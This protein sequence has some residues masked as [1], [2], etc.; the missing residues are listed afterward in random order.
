MKKFLSFLMVLLTS[1]MVCKADYNFDD[2]V[3]PIGSRSY[4]SKAL[5]GE[6]I[7]RMQF[8]IKSQYGGSRYLVEGS[9]ING[10]NSSAFYR[11]KIKDNAVV[12]DFQIYQNALIGSAEYR[13]NIT[14]FAFPI[15]EKPYNWTEI[16]KGDKYQCTSEYVHI[17]ASEKYF[18]AIKI[19]KDN[20][21]TVG[22]EKH[23]EIEKSYWIKGY[24][25]I[26]TLRDLDGV[27]II[28]SQL[29]T[30]GT[31]IFAN[32]LEVPEEEYNAYLKK[33]KEMEIF[34]EAIKP[35]SFQQKYPIYYK[36]VLDII[37]EQ[38][39]TLDSVSSGKTFKITIASN[40]DINIQDNIFSGSPQIDK[41]IKEYLTKLLE[42]KKIILDTATNPETKEIIEIPLILVPT[43]PKMR[44][45]SYN[46]DYIKKTWVVAEQT[47]FAKELIKAAEDYRLKNRKAKNLIISARFLFYNGKSYFRGVKRIETIKD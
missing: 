19:T 25:R 14:I 45:Q 44:I 6:I 27:E 29:E 37:E 7:S 35:Q 16:H 33:Q 26:I 22:K 18:E 3:Y 13:D 9:T 36:E 47:P 43:K 11:Y 8:S 23:R 2:Y 32:V 38:I 20:T 31:D 17:M 12:S 28:S 10:I 30:Q 42:E 46:V 41:S 21:F 15:D 1:N 34:K 5:N 39:Y 24:G 4:Y 40:N